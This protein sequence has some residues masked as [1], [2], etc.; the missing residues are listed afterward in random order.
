[1]PI[2][3]L[4]VKVVSRGKGQSVV[5]SA[6]YRASEA[7]HD[8]RYGITHDYTRKQ[9]VEHSE[10]LLP[11][12]APEWMRDRQ[13][14][15]NAVESTEKRK[16]SQL[17]RE[18]E[19]GLP[20]ELTHNEN[21]D[22]VRDYVQKH[23][24]DKGMVADFSIHEDD[25]NNPHAHVLLT[26]RQ[27]SENG[28]GQKVRS[29][30]AKA[31]LLKW[32]AAWA[33]TA[34]EHLAQAGHNVRIDHRTLEAQNIELEPGRKI[35][36][37]RERQEETKLPRHIAE[38][39]KDAE[40]IAHENGELI[41]QDPTIAL[42]T[43]T[44]QRSTFTER[45][46]AKFLHTR[47]H[48]AEQ[49]QA[50]FLKVTT[51]DELVALGKDDR[52]IIRYTTRDMLEAEKS[53]LHR[54]KVLDGR[55]GH[56][57][58]ASRQ[59]SALSQSNL[60]AEQE[61]AFKH[62]TGEG[63]L[64]ALV[65]VAGSGK[66]TLL[67]AARQAWEAEGLTVKGAALS[68]IAADN[69]EIASGIKSRTLASY[70]YTWKE[71]RDALT[72]KDVLVIDEAGMIGTK[73]LE[74]MLAAADKAHAKVVLVGD[75]EQLQAIEAGAA[76]RGVVGQAGIVEL[77]QVRRQKQAWGR[78][79]TQALATGNTIE[80]L[81]AYQSHGA[82]VAGATRE[83]AQ[84]QLLSAWSNDRKA[85]PNESRLILAYTRDDVRG[86]N[87]EAREILKGEGRLGRGETVQ[88]TRGAREFATGDRIMF[89]RNEKSL[90]VKNGTLGTVERIGGGALQVR[91]D[92]KDETRIAIETKDYQDVDYGYASTIHK[93]QGATVDRS[94]VLAS[95]YFDRHTSYVALSRHRES[96]TLF[97]A[98]DEFAGRRGEGA[99][100]PVE[101]KRNLEYTLA[102]A[103]PKELA[104]DY[105]EPGF[106]DKQ[107]TAAVDL[108]N[109]PEGLRARAREA[110]AAAR[111]K[112][113]QA[114]ASPE[115]IQRL[116]RERWQQY[117]QGQAA[118]QGRTKEK[119]GATKSQDRSLD[120]DD[121]QS[122]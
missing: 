44:H 60:S 79:A 108:D 23:F 103:R 42:R 68:G 100:D 57:V 81:D 61:T 97:Y 53:L 86:L 54:S 43:M 31:D 71:G 83:E 30:N 45:D 24:V 18:I 5:A 101:S 113:L 76:F 102:R 32:R 17:A 120:K 10:I 111:A 115:D 116:A 15:W 96:A 29:W 106:A 75:P 72:K 28:F 16:D 49:F 19:I 65:G 107:P 20:I 121:E 21:V 84:R 41:L 62:V 88:T 50:A 39:I 11:E 38:R 56:E 69:L 59:T 26:M 3:H 66:S 95:H 55:R 78:E 112:D 36:I 94:Y 89:L 35:G 51:S 105:L 70:E 67:A 2:Y 9:G 74:R 93:S 40:R 22:L 90:G 104:H 34:N 119:P 12:G 47:T 110:W 1:V 118:D 63:D 109:S 8:E 122:L 52:N 37:G 46:I 85:N 117:R 82:I 48:G 92:G 33:E 7:L 64:K 99:V 14:L 6:A 73:Q 58:A 114:G 80:A 98:Q 77:T 87:R 27:V 13:T 4:S 25:P 91:L